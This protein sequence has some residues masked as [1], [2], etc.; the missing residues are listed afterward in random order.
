MN[1][2]PDKRVRRLLAAGLLLASGLCGAE[3]ATPTDAAQPAAGEKLEN[4]LREQLAAAEAHV[5]V[6]AIRALCE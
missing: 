5:T 2:R 3:E 6:G 4:C 1:G